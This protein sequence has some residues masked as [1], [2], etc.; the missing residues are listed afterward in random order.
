MNNWSE[1]QMEVVD[2][3]LTGQATDQQRQML[4]QWKDASPTFTQELELYQE[5]YNSL[6][7]QDLQTTL[8]TLNEIHQGQKRQPNSYR[9]WW[10]AASVFILAIAGWW[11]LSSPASFAEI[12]QDYAFETDRISLT[13]ASTSEERT[14]VE[15]ESAYNSGNYRSAIDHLTIALSQNPN[16]YLIQQFL[17]Q[18]YYHN[19]GFTQAAN[20]FQAIR[21][22]KEV[23]FDIRQRS[24]EWEIHS[25][26][27]LGKKQLT[28]ELIKNYELQF[29]IQP[30]ERML[31]LRDEL[32]QAE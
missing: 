7:D 23:L 16:D 3:V 12:Q 9:F 6:H 1:I 25:M 2:A 22:N 31:Q 8:D 26:L 15:A 5:V 11:A 13:T 14:R 17:G 27:A 4:G 19:G 30:S 20:I 10:A 21:T 24:A 18:A 32:I 28:L 29:E